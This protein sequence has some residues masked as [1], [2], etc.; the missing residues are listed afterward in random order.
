MSY[1]KY[2]TIK[3]LIHYKV[4]Y[5]NIIYKISDL[6][7]VDNHPQFFQALLDSPKITKYTGC[8]MQHKQSKY[9]MVE[10]IFCED[11]NRTDLSLYNSESFYL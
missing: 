11:N 6:S 10:I 2:N 8:V 4:F 9:A 7:S 1:K 3:I 5:E